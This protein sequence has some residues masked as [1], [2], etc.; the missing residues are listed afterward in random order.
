VLVKSR[1]GRRGRERERERER[2]RGRKGGRERERESERERSL[3]GTSILVL[4]LRSIELELGLQ[5]LKTFGFTVMNFFAQ[6]FFSSRAVV[7]PKV[8]ESS[9]QK[10]KVFEGSRWPEGW[11]SKTKGFIKPLALAGG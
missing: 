5:L 4:F 7:K 10:P 2:E 8:S 9:L 6:M 1:E 3:F 11:V